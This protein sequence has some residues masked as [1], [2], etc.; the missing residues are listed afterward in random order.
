MTYNQ[1]HM[2]G[3]KGTFSTLL[4]NLR[5]RK[6]EISHDC[7]V[8]FPFSGRY[9]QTK[10]SVEFSGGSN[11]ARFPLISRISARIRSREVSSNLAKFLADPILPLSICPQPYLWTFGE[12]CNGSAV[13][14]VGRS[15]E[16]RVDRSR[17]L[18]C[19]KLCVGICMILCGFWTLLFSMY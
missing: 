19:N 4:R 5:N 11:L 8:L 15:L 10:S 9:F 6:S 18:G 3:M 13:V 16:V 7:D 1:L 14:T 2:S 17:S 12:R